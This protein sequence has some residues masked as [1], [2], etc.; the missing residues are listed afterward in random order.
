MQQVFLTLQKHPQAL[1]LYLDR[2]SKKDVFLVF[3]LEFKLKRLDS[4]SSA[5]QDVTTFLQN[6]KIPEQALVSLL[7]E[8]N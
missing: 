5:L 1:G 4:E 3:L 8:H 6:N 2:V 7:R